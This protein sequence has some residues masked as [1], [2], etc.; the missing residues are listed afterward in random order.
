MRMR[1]HV[2]NGSPGLPAMSTRDAGSLPTEIVARVWAATARP[3]RAASVSRARALVLR[4]RPR[5]TDGD[6]SR[7]TRR[8]YHAARWRRPEQGGDVVGARTPEAIGLDNVDGAVHDIEPR[9]HGGVDGRATD[10]RTA[11]RDQDAAVGEARRRRIDACTGRQLAG[12]DEA[13]IDHEALELGD[14]CAVRIDAADHEH[15]AAWVSDVEAESAWIDA[16]EIDNLA[17]PDTGKYVLAKW[18]CRRTRRSDQVERPVHSADLVHRV[19]ARSASSAR[20]FGRF[21]LP[22]TS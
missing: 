22:P 11:A 20:R 19:F 1:S 21:S 10:G 18:S 17:I 15:T 3:A 2:G 4:T 16:E 8:R 14:R 13:G 7:A 6:N 12:V 9:D 5:R